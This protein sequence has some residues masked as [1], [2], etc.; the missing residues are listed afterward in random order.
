MDAAVAGAS[1]HASSAFG[2]SASD[3]KPQVKGC[4]AGNGS[5]FGSS[6]CCLITVQTATRFGAAA[7]SRR[8]RSITVLRDN[9][10]AKPIADQVAPA[11]RIDLIVISASSVQSLGFG[12]AHLSAFTPQQLDTITLY[13]KKY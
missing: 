12:M 5:R 9:P 6:A 7:Q 2:N 1:C 13:V 10:S 8:P 4:P 11:A 3:N